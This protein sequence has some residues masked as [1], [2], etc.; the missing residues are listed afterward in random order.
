[1]TSQVE[2]RRRSLRNKTEVP[3]SYK[4]EN[5]GKPFRAETIRERG[6][7][8]DRQR[9]TDRQTERKKQRERE[10]EKRKR[11]NQ[12]LALIVNQLR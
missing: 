2:H 8:R 6:K 12:K 4:D 10:E 11:N 9:Q 3:R 7:D 5:K 1:M